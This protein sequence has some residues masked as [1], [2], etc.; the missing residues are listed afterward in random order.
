MLHTLATVNRADF[1]PSGQYRYWLERHWQVGTPILSIIMLNPSRADHSVDDPTLRRVMG[2]AQ[3]WGFG[4]LIVVNLF[5]YR[6][7]YPRQLRQVADPV[8]AGNDQAL[9][10]AAALGDRLLLAWGNGG[11]WRHRDRQ[12]ITLLQPYW[13]K[14]CAIGHNRT[15]Q[16]RHPLYARRDVIL[17][18]Q[19]RVYRCR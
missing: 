3:G 6:T 13:H 11:S 19:G 8:G 1:D 9:L 2:L 18:P 7:P 17:Q 12:V 5:A 15:G 10:A 14:W 16:P 4:A